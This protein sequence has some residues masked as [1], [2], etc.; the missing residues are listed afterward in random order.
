[1]TNKRAYALSARIDN[2][3]A[4]LDK[5]IIP[6]IERHAA[7]A[8][9]LPV[10]KFAGQ[11]KDLITEAQVRAFLLDPLLEE[12]GWSITTTMLVEAG[13][14]A[15]NKGEYRRFLDYLGVGSLSETKALILVEAKRLS[16]KLPL[17]ENGMDPKRIIIDALIKSFTPDEEIVDISAEWVKILR[18][19]ANYVDRLKNNEY[20]TPKRAIL[21]N[22][23]WL[24]VFLNPAKSLLERRLDPEDFIVAKSLPEAIK[25]APE[26]VKALAYDHLAEFLP[27]MNCED[28]RTYVNPDDGQLNA[29]LSYEVF[30]GVVA[31]SKVEIGFQPSVVVQIPNGSWVRFIDDTQSHIMIR[32]TDKLDEDMGELKQNSNAL[33]QKLLTQAQ[34][35]MI[36]SKTYEDLVINKPEFPSTTLIRLEKKEHHILHTG[37]ISIPFIDPGSYSNCPYH[38]HGPAAAEGHAVTESPITRRSLRPLVHFPSGSPI[39]CASRRTEN[40][41][42]DCPM[43]AITNYVCCRACSLQAR[44]WPHGMD[45][46][47]CIE[48]PDD[49]V[50]VSTLMD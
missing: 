36:D 1:M 15:I 19:L 13:I 14:E 40:L 10:E 28:L 27:A 30:S 8:S 47:P 34:L 44:C 33:V 9:N 21:A 3:V 2:L 35:T 32:G 16:L 29:V 43:L 46:L 39:H 45:A 38:S 17:H 42:K 6:F 41:K 23:D 22:G 49:D 37:D 31:G 5:D 4:A 20:G 25:L 18:T 11:G 50:D 7:L 26:L 12:L 24:V 48:M